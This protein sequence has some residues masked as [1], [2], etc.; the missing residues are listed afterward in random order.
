MTCCPFQT[1]PTSESAVSSTGDPMHH[2]RSKMKPEEE[3]PSPGAVCVQSNLQQEE[4]VMFL[5]RSAL[6]LSYNNPPNTERAFQRY[7][8]A[9]LTF[10]PRQPNKAAL[11]GA[12]AHVTKPLLSGPQM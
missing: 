9:L 3:M 10:L 6:V 11:T 4:G 2:K 5:K 7:T 12:L 1:K 8:S